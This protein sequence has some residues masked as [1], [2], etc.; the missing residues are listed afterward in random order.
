[1]AKYGWKVSACMH[2][3]ATTT[4]AP[5]GARRKMSSMMPGTPIASKTTAG[6]VPSNGDPL[7]GST[8]VVAPVL[9]ASSR[10]RAE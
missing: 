6:V 3:P 4:R 5:I 8:V 1:M 7:A 9:S 2:T 10:R